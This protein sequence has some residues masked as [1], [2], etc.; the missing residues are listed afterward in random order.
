MQEPLEAI[1]RAVAQ[2]ASA[3]QKATGAQAC[4]MILTALE[5]EPGKPLALQSGPALQPLAGIDPD[6]ALDLLIARLLASL[7]AEDAPAPRVWRPETS[8]LRLALVRPP[9]G[10]PRRKR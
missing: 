7:P 2:D 9:P 1:Q 4:R 6:Q 3:E 8:G 5:A 10:P